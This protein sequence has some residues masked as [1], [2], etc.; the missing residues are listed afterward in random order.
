MST[1]QT[2]GRLEHFED[3]SSA[4]DSLFAQAYSQKGEASFNEFINFI[5]HFNHLSVYNAMLVRIQRPGSSAVGTLK[6]WQRL[7]RFIKPT[8]VPIVILQAFGPVSFLYEY[9]DTYGETLFDDSENPLRAK[10]EI[11]NKAL[12]KTIEKAETFGIKVNLVHNY[13]A[14][15]AGNA[16]RFAET[17]KNEGQKVVYRFE[18]NINANLDEATQY[19]TLAHELAHIYCGHLGQDEKGRWPNRVHLSTPCKELEAEATSWLVS[20]RLAINSNSAAYLSGYIDGTN[21]T[22]ISMYAIFEAA[23]RIEA[24]KAHSKK[25]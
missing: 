20:K 24:K 21:L 13:G 9:G 10:G 5:E 4:I 22:Q 7:N 18:I 15:L 2:K 19:A 17:V 6:Q 3:C 12:K 16:T 1:A 8:A 23:N 11:P 25:K 14:F